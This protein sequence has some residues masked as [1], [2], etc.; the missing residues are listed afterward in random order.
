MNW[1][2]YE[3]TCENKFYNP[4]PTDN[5]ED[6]PDV[7]SNFAALNYPGSEEREPELPELP[8]VI[9]EI[10]EI[11]EEETSSTLN[12]PKRSTSMNSGSTTTSS[13][14]RSVHYLDG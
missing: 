7:D 12:V 10:G 11:E 1:K 13:S 4:L 14:A 2:K 5:P 9:G 6:R 8:K 3:G